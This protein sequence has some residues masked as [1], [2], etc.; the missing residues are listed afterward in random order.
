MVKKQKKKEENN[1]NIAKELEPEN[2]FKE[3]KPKK[4]KKQKK[5]VDVEKLKEQLKKKCT[6]IHYMIVCEG[7]RIN[8]KAGRYWWTGTVV[9]AGNLG[10][11]VDNGG[12]RAT[13]SRSKILSLTILEEGE[14][15]K[16]YKKIYR[17]DLEEE[18]D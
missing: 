9:K 11:V 14:W 10:L 15:K 7:D 4:E 17:T 13:I 12:N 1:I 6:S 18:M 3:E 16:K 5:K 2:V 8:V